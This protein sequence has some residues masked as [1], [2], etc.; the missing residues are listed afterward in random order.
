MALKTLITQI[1]PSPGL[2]YSVFIAAPVFENSNLI[3]DG[4]GNANNISGFTDVVS[5]DTLSSIRSRL[6]A[7]FATSFNAATGRTD[8]SSIQF[9]WLDDKGIL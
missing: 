7:D 3:L 4:S 9:V 6:I 5:T 2:H 8:G 1:A